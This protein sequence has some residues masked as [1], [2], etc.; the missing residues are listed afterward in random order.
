MLSL[1]CFVR[2]AI[3]MELLAGRFFHICWLSSES[4]LAKVSDSEPSRGEAAARAVL[5]TALC[6]I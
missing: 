4:Q 2:W 5:R 3:S 1:F 6:F